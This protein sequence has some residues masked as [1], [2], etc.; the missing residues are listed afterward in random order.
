MLPRIP[1]P[2]TE[3]WAAFF[4]LHFQ[5]HQKEMLPEPL[6][7][8]GMFWAAFPDLRWNRLDLT[9]GK[10][11]PGGSQI[12]LYTRS[13]PVSTAADRHERSCAGPASMLINSIL[14]RFNRPVYAE[15]Q[16]AREGKRP[17]AHSW[18]PGPS[19]I[20]ASRWTASPRE[21]LLLHYQDRPAEP[22]A[23]H[24]CAE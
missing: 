13:S 7:I 15:P 9:G 19:S 12:S 1:N 4:L 22:W 18:H 3:V 20:R 11:G 5:H 14:K 10:G 8:W 2:I 23:C 24:P 16:S 21:S 6:C 17:P